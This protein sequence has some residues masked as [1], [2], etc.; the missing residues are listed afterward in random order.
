MWP[1]NPT[2]LGI[3]QDRLT[4]LTPVPWRPGAG[5]RQVDG[6]DAAG[7]ATSSP[8]DMA[9]PLPSGPARPLP[10]DAAASSPPD[11]TW[12]DEVALGACWTCFPRGLAG[13][14]AA[15][16]PAWTAA[17]VLRGSQVLDRQ[18]LRGAAAAPYVPGLLALRLGALMEPAVRSLARRPEVLLVD[19]TARDHPRRAGLALM[20]GAQLDLPT[21]GITRRPLV[22]T[23]HW[24]DDDDGATSP[25]R[26]GD[27]VVA[28]W[29]RTRA[30]SR[31]VAV[32]PG[33][34]V[35]LDTAVAVVAWTTERHRTP[36]PLRCARQAARKARQG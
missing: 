33:W 17:V 36:E 11:P 13:P 3:A 27:E 14:G 19:A 26:I 35:D 6:G 32:H 30:G 23:G 2:E 10:P 12:L 9:A 24:P 7:P 5:C 4:G 28:C 16:D 15:G 8:P 22:A 1:T 29:L 20:L 34:R 21:I 18:T 31:P 25:L